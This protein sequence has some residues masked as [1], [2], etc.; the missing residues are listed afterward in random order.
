MKYIPGLGSVPVGLVILICRSECCQ[1]H[2]R[3]DIGSKQQ[4]NMSEG[5]AIPLCGDNSGSS[6]WK[7]SW[8]YTQLGKMNRLKIEVIGASKQYGSLMT[9]V[10][11]FSSFTLLGNRKFEILSTKM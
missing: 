9:L 3:S 8:Y 6:N 4:Q 2:C 11:N 1:P 5:I 10:R 7:P